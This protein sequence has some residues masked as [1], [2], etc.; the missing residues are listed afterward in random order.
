MNHSK[1]ESSTA[2]DV[3]V[4]VPV[5]NAEETLEKS[6]DSVICQTGLN[7]EIICIDDGST[8]NSVRQ[9]E[10]LQ[11]KYPQVLLLEQEH[12]GSGQAR[13]TGILAAR[14][15]Y[16]AFL[17]S[18]D[19]FVDAEAL[20]IMVRAC[21][22]YHAYIC[23]SLRLV[24]ENGTEQNSPLFKN[25][26]IPENGCFI[27]YKDFQYDYDYQSFIFSREFLIQNNIFFPQYLRY[28]D[29]PFFAKAMTVAER[30]FVA[31]VIL[32]KYTIEPSKRK[33]I[34]KYSSHILQG[35]RDNLELASVNG[36]HKLFE[37]NVKRIDEDYYDF[38][39]QNLNDESMSLLLVINKMSKQFQRKELKI[40]SDIYDA[41]ENNSRLAYSH[42]LMRQIIMVKQYKGG[43]RSYFEKYQIQAVAVYGLGVYGKILINELKEC[44]IEIVCG[45]DRN[46]SLYGNLHII[47]PENNVPTCDALIVSMMDSDDVVCQYQT[48]R[49]CKVYTF[50][51]II[52]E[53]AEEI[54][55]TIVEDMI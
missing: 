13:N 55:R 50:Q 36:Y 4:I 14:G 42:N 29:P 44:G 43:F 1:N 22:E 48:R 32:Y 5:F 26:Q 51:Q 21:D 34:M 45:I 52:Q 47:R 38:I 3:S 27:E 35:I 39:S 37:N 41:G 12:Q 10:M 18:D 25:Y 15:K 49:D 30:F 7:I 6:I 23:G 8:D 46:I 53:M 20:H 40:L 11:K 28:Q 24:F 31:P 9:I 19:E 16:I 2:W 54:E 33:L 17:D